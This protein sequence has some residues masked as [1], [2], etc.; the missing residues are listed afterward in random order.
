MKFYFTQQVSTGAIGATSSKNIFS[1]ASNTFA[2]EC[3]EL[4][5]DTETA[6]H[7]KART[8]GRVPL[9]GMSNGSGNTFCNGHTKTLKKST[10]KG[11]QGYSGLC[12]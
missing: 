8:D 3:Q 2:N 1:M 4:N 10:Y 7:K 11:N 12:S 6:E 5:G 9:N